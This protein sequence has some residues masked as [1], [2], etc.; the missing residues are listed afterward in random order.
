MLR[1]NLSA[2]LNCNILDT[3]IV[4]HTRDGSTVKLLARYGYLEVIKG[5]AFYIND[6]E[7]VDIIER[8]VEYFQNHVFTWIIHSGNMPKIYTSELLAS[9]AK[10]GNIFAISLIPP[11]VV[12]NYANWLV[13]TA[14]SRGKVDICEYLTDKCGYSM[15]LDQITTAVEYNQQETALFIL[16]RPNVPF[17]ELT[18]QFALR[19]SNPVIIRAICEYSPDVYKEFLYYAKKVGKEKILD[20]LLEN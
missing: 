13:S 1:K 16:K 9:A 20:T 12:A 2:L 11:N 14:V 18:Y 3:S 5:F 19:Y 17:S 8:S 6:S 10:F 4:T 15:E 7:I